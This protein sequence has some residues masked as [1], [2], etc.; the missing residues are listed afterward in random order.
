MSRSLTTRIETLER[1]GASYRPGC[2][3]LSER[4]LRPDYLAA[5]IAEHQRA[6]REVTVIKAWYPGKSIRRLTRL[7]VRFTEEPPC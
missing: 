3:Y 4:H 1:R 5:K 6:G 7:P 2:V